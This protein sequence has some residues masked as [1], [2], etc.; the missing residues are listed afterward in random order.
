MRTDNM[1]I[2]NP[3]GTKRS[4][5]GQIMSCSDAAMGRASSR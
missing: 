3:A 2:K 1:A 5:I 4:K